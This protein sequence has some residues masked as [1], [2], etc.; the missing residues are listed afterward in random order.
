MPKV[1]ISP[2]TQENNIGVGNYGT[3]E[4]RMNQIA[5]KVVPLL[6]YNGFTVYRNSPSMSLQQVVADSNRR[7]V[8][9]HIAIHSNAGGGRGTEVFYTSDRGKPLASSL[10]KYAE[11]LTPTKD[12][13]IK[14]TDR[15]YELN[16]T[17]AAAAL[18]EVAFHDNRDDAE[19]ILNNMDAIAE[20]IA[21]G[22][23]DYFNVGFKK[24]Q[25]QKPPQEE[26]GKLFKVQVG[27]FSEKDNAERLAKE[28][29]SKG[30]NVYIYQ[31]KLYKV[32]VG[33]FAKRENA[34]KLGEELRAK[35]Y[36]TFIYEE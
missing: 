4:R 34:E 30:Y 7:N 26:T 27:A 14:H 19:F 21:R 13:G 2:S 9:A 23:C 1:Y 18:I 31:D 25:P 15:L 3:E 22:I 32:Q 12:R 36:N 11:P 35:G 8:D 6:Q 20:A 29:K 5:D 24:P 10:Y 28:L 16:R 33:A 17:K